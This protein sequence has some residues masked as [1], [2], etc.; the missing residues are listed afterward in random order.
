MLAL[1]ALITPSL[2]L[3]LQ[4]DPDD[5]GAY[6]EIQD[7][8][9]A[10]R[11][12][13]TITIAA[14]SYPECLD[15]R[16]LMLTLEGAGRYTTTLDCRGGAD[17]AIDISSGGTVAISGL[18][19]E[20]TG[21]RGIIA[22][23]AALSLSDVLIEGTGTTSGLHGGA[24][25][26][27]GGDVTLDDIELDHNAAAYGAAMYVTG[28]AVV[29]VSTATIT[30]GWAGYGG[31]IYQATDDTVGA[32]LVTLI[33]AEITDNSATYGGAIWVEADGELETEG[34]TFEDNTGTYGYG[35]AVLMG[36]DGR[37][38]STDDTFS[39]NTGSYYNYGQVYVSAGG[40]LDVDGSSFTGGSTSYGGGIYATNAT[41][42]IEGATFDSNTATYG[43]AVYADSNST[44]I[45]GDSDFTDNT[46]TYYGGGL[47]LSGGVASISD[48]T[49]SGGTTTYY[50]GAGIYAA[51]LTALDLDTVDFDANDASPGYRGYGGAV[52]ATNTPIWSTDSTFADNTALNNGGAVYLSGQGYDHHFGGGSFTSNV[53]SSSGGG[54]Y[55]YYQV[56]TLS[57]EEVDFDGN[58]AASGGGAVYG[59]YYVDLDISES[60]FTDNTAPSAGAVANIYYGDASV[61]LS[62]FSGNDASSSNGGA[63]YLYPYSQSYDQ[64]VVLSDF[65]DNSAGGHGAGLYAYVPGELQLA[66][67]S[68][69]GNVAS[70][71]SSSGGGVYLY[72]AQQLE[73]RN[74]TFCGNE[75]V[76]GGGVYSYYGGASDEWTNNVF[77]ENTADY[78]GGFYPYYHTSIEVENNTFIGNDGG[79]VGGGLYGYYTYVDF[80]NNI[81][82]YTADGDGVYSAD[83]YSGYYS[84]FEYTAASDNENN[85]AGGYWEIEIDEDGNID[86]DPDFT[87]YSEDADCT[88]DDLSLASSSALIDAGDPDILDTDGST[89]DIGH[90]GGEYAANVDDDGDGFYSTSDCDDS[91]AAIYPGADEVCDG[92]D[93]DCDGETDEDA[94][95]DAITWYIDADGD[96]E[97]AETAWQRDCDEPSGYVDN[98][99]DC[100]DSDADIHTGGTEI[101]YDGID[102][103][104]DGADFADVDGDGFDW[105]GVRGGTDCDDDDANVSPDAT[106]IWYDGVDQDCDGW[107]DDDADQDSYDAE[108]AGGSDCDDTDADISPRADE[109]WYDGVDQ[110]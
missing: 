2:A 71:S 65:E 21:A 102:Q 17:N 19:I 43:G 38:N 94:A 99:D 45:V 30:D 107:S 16:G 6:D 34:C 28:A 13:D 52:F 60:T 106:E 20:N 1:L 31:A 14:G 47:F 35:P 79:Y 109:T 83:S 57:F 15:T 41:L 67:N 23:D 74:N 90:G 53:A 91:D 9:D 58:E 4:V 110:D 33:D 92:S 70:G 49:F 48:S 8:I 5:A 97:G 63:L 59:I 77:Q 55:S 66:E 104:C 93:N 62:T 40:S 44:V 25:Y 10:A 27:E 56:G 32:P 51:S 96:G 69:T 84:D 22:V 87:D 39:T 73:V 72:R 82:A 86:D 29:T 76:Y 81:V 46:G 68:F 42:H 24:L 80:L 101:A 7:A 36:A 85:D 18:A 64:S 105:D 26:I 89:S 50:Y 98:T 108:A 37:Y 78:G 88:N 54:V 100:D 75:A 61:S 11:T 3:T 12:G 103:D 95:T